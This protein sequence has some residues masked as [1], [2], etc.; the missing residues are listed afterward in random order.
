MPIV[1]VKGDL[2]SYRG[3][4]AICHGCNCA[5]AMGKGI[6]IE[7]RKK[8]PLMFSEYKKKCIEG[9]FNVG[10]VF[11]WK[12]ESIAIFNLGTQKNWQTKATIQAIVKSVNKMVELA[13]KHNIRN[14]GVPRVGAGLGGLNWDDV[15]NELVKIGKNTS[16]ELVVFETFQQ[17][18]EK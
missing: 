8:Y 14:I 12:E 10:D 7:F 9:T 5:G 2:F 17:A 3:L 4:D 13:I 1:F 15:K 18:K 6:A 11:L 16:V